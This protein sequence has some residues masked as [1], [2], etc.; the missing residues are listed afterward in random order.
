MPGLVPPGLVERAVEAAWPG[1]RTETAPGRPAAAGGGWPPAAN[2]AWPCPSTTRCAPST[3][4][5]P[6]RPLLGALAGLEE[7]ESACVQILARP[8]TG[9]R[10]AR[11]HRAAAARR[12]GR[13]ATRAGPTGRPGHPGTEHAQPAASD[14]TRERDV[15]DILDKAAQPCWAVAVRYAVAT[16]ATDA[17]AAGPP[18]GPSPCRGLGVR[19]SSPDATA[20]TAAG[21]ATPPRPWPHGASAGAT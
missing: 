11:L 1:A 2:C 14:P 6:L 19:R 16:T 8:V 17:E 18:A 3:R 21:C 12:T 4:S 10:L 20:S 15:A 5:T 13:P 7:D 9:R